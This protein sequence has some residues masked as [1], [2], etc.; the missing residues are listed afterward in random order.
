MKIRCEVYSV[1][2]QYALGYQEGFIFVPE[3]SSIELIK[4]YYEFAE[5]NSTYKKMGEI[6]TEQE[7]FDNDEFEECNSP[8]EPQKCWYEYLH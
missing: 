6:L 3:T 7:F 8:E 2:M 5:K 4:N 1:V